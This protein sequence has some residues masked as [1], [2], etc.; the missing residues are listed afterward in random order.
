MDLPQEDFGDVFVEVRLAYNDFSNRDSLALVG[1]VSG[2]SVYLKS[3]GSG[4]GW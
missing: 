3:H 1:L 2:W 4:T